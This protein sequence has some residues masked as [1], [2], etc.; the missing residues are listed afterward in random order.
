MNFAAGAAEFG[1]AQSRLRATGDGATEESETNALDG[2]GTRTPVEDWVFTADY[3]LPLLR[4]QL[5]VHSLDGMGMAGH[6][7]AGVAAGAIVHY[8]RHTKQGALEHLDNAAV[9]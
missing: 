8:L 7:A 9:L 5:R 4:Q 6:E 1:S 3:A 2:V